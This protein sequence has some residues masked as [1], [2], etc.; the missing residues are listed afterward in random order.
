[1]PNKWTTLYK[2]VSLNRVADILDNNRL[3]LNDGS[4]FNDPFEITTVDR[5][6]HKIRHIE[7][8]HVLSLTNIEI[9]LYGH[10]IQ[11]RIAAFA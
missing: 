10:T 8:L 1:M 11:I 4:N 6:T 3:Y 5:R 7:G 2:Y 9:N